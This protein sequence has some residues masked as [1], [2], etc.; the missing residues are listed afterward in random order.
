[1]Q[2]AGEWLTRLHTA[3]LRPLG[4]PPA[5]DP[6]RLWLALAWLHAALAVWALLL[7]LLSPVA[8]MPTEVELANAAGW[9]R[10][11]VG[12]H[13]SGLPWLFVPYGRWP[14]VMYALLP[15]FGNPYLTGRLVSFAATAVLLWVVARWTRAWGGD[16]RTVTLVVLVALTARPLLEYGIAMRVDL[17]VVL[18]GLAGWRLGITMDDTRRRWAGVVLLVIALLGKLTALTMPLAAVCFLWPRR[19]REAIEVILG[20]TLLTALGVAW[21]QHVSDGAF[22]TVLGSHEVRPIHGLELLSRLYSISFPW[23]LALLGLIVCVPIEVHRR[24]AAVRWMLF[25]GYLVAYLTGCNLGAS[26]NYL[27]DLFL[28]CWLI[29]AVLY[30]ERPAQ[31]CG[32]NRW[33]RFWLVLHFGYCLVQTSCR[34]AW[35]QDQTATVAPQ[36]A[37]AADTLSAL[38]DDG[39]AAIL[40]PPAAAE[41]WLNLGRLNWIAVPES[42]GLDPAPAAEAAL[43]DGHLDAVVEGD[44]PGGLVIRRKF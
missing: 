13:T 10:L 28:A 29:T 8:L 26:W 7:G 9:Y 1:M 3:A 44:G 40:G 5:R 4:E 25:A 36:V 11:G 33:I 23:H 32:L 17:P 19:R 39:R 14:I 30:A 35:L 27:L 31:P 16:R 21:Q 20:V 38:P 42:A 15:R 6:D 43:R 18:L 12:P 2:R 34:I 24:G 22:L 41:A 37:A